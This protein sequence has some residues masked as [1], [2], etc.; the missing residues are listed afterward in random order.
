[1]STFIEISFGV[2]AVCIAAAFAVLF[3]IKIN[4]YDINSPW[5]YESRHAL[6]AVSEVPRTYIPEGARVL[7]KE[8][9]RARMEGTADYL[10]VPVAWLEET[11]QRGLAERLS[12][13]RWVDVPSNEWPTVWQ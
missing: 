10:R 3:H 6:G 4:A 5:K 12:N 2:L 9:W 13:W 1:M 11:Y 7:Y 8:L